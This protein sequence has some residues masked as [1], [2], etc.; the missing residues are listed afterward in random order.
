MLIPFSTVGGIKFLDSEYLAPFA[1]EIK[2][3]EVYAR[4]SE[5]GAPYFAV[6]RGMCLQA[7]IM[8]FNAVNK[9]FVDNIE[10]IYSL[11]KVAL[12]NKEAEEGC[13]IGIFDGEEGEK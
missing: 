5:K 10:K 8:P 6:K 9:S 1:G 3:I 13:Q 7:I 4:I 11:C 2:E 12:L